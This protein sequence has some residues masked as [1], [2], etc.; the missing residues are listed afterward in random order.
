MYLVAVRRVL[1]CAGALCLDSA[2]SS[3]YLCAR[4]A[5]ASGGDQDTFQNMDMESCCRIPWWV[6]D[7]ICCLSNPQDFDQDVI[8]YEFLSVQL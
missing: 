5:V 2:A 7:D 8:V 3:Q 1:A 4:A 6:N